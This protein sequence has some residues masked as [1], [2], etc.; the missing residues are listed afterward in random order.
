MQKRLFILIAVIGILAAACSSSAEGS[1]D[2][3]APQPV[4]HAEL[5]TEITSVGEPSVVNSWASWCP[6]CRS[7]A[8]L[9]ASA[10]KANEDVHFVMLNTNDDPANATEFIAQTFADAPMAQYADP[11]GQVTFAMGGGRGLPVTMFYDTDGTLV[12]IH[13]GILDE[14]TL[15]FYLDEIKR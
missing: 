2:A 6:P 4:T 5:M 15:A 1:T 12:Q 3:G 10:A 14:P 9:L 8:P 13:R 7:E 11:T